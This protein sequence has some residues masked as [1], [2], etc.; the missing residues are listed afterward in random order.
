MLIDKDYTGKIKSTYECDRCKTRIHT[1]TDAR[2]RVA[3]QNTSKSLTVI[4]SWDLC[5]RCYVAL[6]RGIE[7]G[8]V[9]RDGESNGSD[10]K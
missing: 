3:V 2:Y 5:K 9:R 7:K 10:E 1:A 4:K 6:Y 8:V